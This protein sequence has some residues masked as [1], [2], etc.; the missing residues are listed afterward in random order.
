MWNAIPTMVISIIKQD[1]HGNPK[2]CNYCIVALGN[3]DPHS[4]IKADCFAPVLSQLE[5]RLLLSIATHKRVTPK[6]GY[7]SQAFVQLTL[8]ITKQYIVKYPPGCPLTKPNSYFQLIW[9]LYG[10]KQSPRHWHKKATKVLESLGLKNVHNSQCTYCGIILLG[11]PSLYVGLYV[12]NLI[13]FSESSKIKHAFEAQFNEQISTN[14]HGLVTHFLRLLVQYQQHPSNHV[15]ITLIQELFIDVLLVK[16]NL[17]F[18][19]VNLTL[20]PYQSGFLVNKITSSTLSRSDQD[21]HNLHSQQLTSCLQWILVSTRPDISAIT[22]LLSKCNH[23]TTL[24]HIKAAH[25]FICYLKGT[26]NLGI[27][28]DNQHNTKLHAYVELPIP[29]TLTPFADVKWG[30]QD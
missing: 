28:F 15:S 5:L 27:S 25:Y 6:Q 1:K 4:W 29:T 18:P 19:L 24:E 23:S 11:Y 30:P 20:T 2:R 3:L 17:N 12:E 10:L 8:P 14:F 16:T 21:K 7:V 13:Y 22:N 9:T 26:K